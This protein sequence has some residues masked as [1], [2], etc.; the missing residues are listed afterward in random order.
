[1]TIERDTLWLITKQLMDRLEKEDGEIY[2]RDKKGFAYF[3]YNT[4][5]EQFPDIFTEYFKDY[6]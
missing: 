4:L 6:D 1:M 3:V 5:E 2:I